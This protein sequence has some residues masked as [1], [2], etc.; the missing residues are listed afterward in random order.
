MNST[1]QQ[2]DTE[3]R[4]PCGENNPI[5]IT[6]SGLNVNGQDN[7]IEFPPEEVNRENMQNGYIIIPAETFNKFDDKGKDK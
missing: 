2:N 1:E 3:Y 7:T 6:G 4:V 5:R